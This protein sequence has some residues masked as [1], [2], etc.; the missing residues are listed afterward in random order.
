MQRF[1]GKRPEVGGALSGS[2]RNVLMITERIQE[3]EAGFRSLTEAIDC[4]NRI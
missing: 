4:D 3:A 2:L 1:S